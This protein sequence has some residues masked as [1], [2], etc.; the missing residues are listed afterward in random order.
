LHVT[1]LDSKDKRPSDGDDVTL[2]VRRLRDL[3]AH[4]GGFAVLYEKQSHFGL[5]ALSAAGE[6]VFDVPA[7]IGNISRDH[8]HQGS[9]AWNGTG[10]AAY[11]GI[12]GGGH[13]GDALRFL[14]Q[15]GHML[16]GGWNWGCSHSIDTRLIASDG[17]F[18]PMCLSD[19]YP[20]AGFNYYH[21]KAFIA[22]VRGST[23][24]Y[25]GGRLGGFAATPAKL[26]LAYN[27]DAN[28]WHAYLALFNKAAPYSVTTSVRLGLAGGQQKQVKVARYGQDQVLVSWLEATTG[29]QMFQIFSEAGVATAPAEALPASVYGRSDFVTHANGDVTWV[30]V[31]SETSLRVQ[32]LR[33]CN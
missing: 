24:G 18:H 5:V 27:S 26:A 1:K 33:S 17:E 28:G 3:T 2:G 14:D 12:S 13:E 21:T 15:E 22:G 8:L 31:E 7:L 10:Y 20:R 29:E 11:F 4:D 32:R 23:S 19:V 6:T 25:T 16:S 30:G 9:V